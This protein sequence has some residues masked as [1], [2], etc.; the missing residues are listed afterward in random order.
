MS[1]QLAL[2]GF[3]SPAVVHNIFLALAPEGDAPDRLTALAERLRTERGLK[4]GSQD[5]ERLHVS[6]HG[7]AEYSA[8]PS[9]LVSNVSAAVGGLS[10]PRFEVTFDRV[11]SFNSGRGNRALV[12]Q[13]QKAQPALEELH[14]TLADALRRHG[15]CRDVR[16]YF[17]PHVTLLYDGK[18]VPEQS[19]EPITWTVTEF[20]LFDSLQGTG[21]YER[22]AHWPLSA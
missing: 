22:L 8:V 12:A 17:T 7:I 5:R 16:S 2:E 11:V 3:E 21:R 10:L 9:R 19:I 4:G 13:A 15:V 6:L 18:V 1:G 14:R 20:V